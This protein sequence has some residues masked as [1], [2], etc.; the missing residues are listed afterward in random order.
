MTKKKGK[1]CNVPLWLV[2]LALFILP[3][4]LIIKLITTIHRKTKTMSIKIKRKGKI[5]NFI[6][7]AFE[8]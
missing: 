3:F 1:Y 4:A 8:E 7:W 6:D 2:G 5:I